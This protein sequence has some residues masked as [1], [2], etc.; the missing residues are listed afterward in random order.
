MNSHH[1][2]F[3]LKQWLHTWR[4]PG[5]IGMLLLLPL[6]AAVHFA[7]AQAP[8]ANTARFDHIKT[9]FNLT[10]AHAQARCSYCHIQGVYKGTPRDCAG[11]HV[12]GNRMG[13]V[14]K[15]TRH[16][17]TVARCDSCHNTSVWIPATFSHVGLA[18]GSC[19]TCHNSSTA[20][21]KPS[22][23]LPA[24]AS[25]DSCH[26]TTIGWLQN[27]AF[28]HQGISSGCGSCHS[29]QTFNAVKPVSKP[30][31][32][33]VTAADCSSCHTSTATFKTASGTAM[34]ANH[35]P[36]AQACAL[37]HNSAGFVPGVM[38][39]AG[40]VSGCASCHNGQNFI[41]V[42]P[43]SKP[44]THLVTAAACETCHTST[45][46][47]LLAAGTSMPAGH[48]PSQMAC[49]TCHSSFG[50]NSGVMSHT[51]IVNG[52]ANCHNG[53]SYVGVTPVSKPPTHLPTSA[54]C[55]TCH[56]TSN[57]T[58][59]SGT[60]MSHAGIVNGCANCHNGQSFAGVTMVFKPTGHLP[61]SAACETCHSTSSFNVGGFAGTAMNHAGIVNGC[62]SCHNGQ[63][64]TGV[65]PV[66]KPTNHLPTSAACET[67]HSTSNFTM[68]SGTLMSHTGIVNGCANCHNGQVF[69]GVTPVSKASFPSHLVTTADCSTCH[70]STV[71]FATG[72][73]TTTLPANHLPTTQTCST[74]HNP[75]SFVPGVMSHTGIVNGC[76]SCHN[77]QS[78]VGVTPVSKPTTHLPT[79]ATCETCHS[80]TKFTAFSGTLMSHTGIVNGCASCHNGQVFSGVTPVSKPTNHLP[81]SATCETCHSTSN[82]T[83]FSGTQMSHA[84]IVNACASC[85]NGQV[86]SGVTPVFKPAN[87]LPT[88]ATCE[89]CHST[90]NFTT[91]SGTLM[92]HT[93]I[94]S[95]CAI[96]HNGQSFAGVTPVSKA[97]SHLPT[98][99]ACETCHS[100]SKFTSFS[101]T[102]MNH[103]GILNNCTICHNGQ[104]FQGVTPVSKPSN[105]IPYA[106]NLTGGSSMG[107]EF[108][109]TPTVFTAFTALTTSTIMHNSTQGN[110]SGWCKTCHA[111]GTSYLGVTGD[112]KSVTHQ[113]ST[114]T[115]CSQ[116]GCH[117]PLG[118]KG[119]SYVNWD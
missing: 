20:S 30:S 14:A 100:T 7:S 53:Q 108:C 10:G 112:K 58:A 69:S 43:V 57:F 40:I 33:V 83:T 48:L 63:S 5:W 101:G 15:P 46:S 55:E 66:P 107:C 97:L 9:G 18:P 28:S 90:S 103:A 88:S 71:S 1:K 85:H 115:D 74:C 84:G 92:K 6:I 19:L 117:K 94:V 91:F 12:E 51:G 24:T 119:T 34:P 75:A 49:S 82:F 62:A 109:H 50:P 2:S 95:G 79:S 54:A 106:A 39:H 21:G 8:E 11:C 45:T 99:L 26:K 17:F 73:S 114:A 32:H 3:E 104:V 31:N 27:V 87:H 68:F 110:G 61:T 111:T 56:S 102:A 89:T 93:G 77:G 70:T 35:L 86:F 105:H 13:A 118:S 59:F 47:F 98:S 64:F 65:T 41:G 22:G 81:T 23:H 37:C 38:N 52:C 96:C 72:V 78:F 67:C 116:S 16:I 60:A 29:G 44:T 36:T 25:C 80:P 4:S 42:T 113:S 76:A